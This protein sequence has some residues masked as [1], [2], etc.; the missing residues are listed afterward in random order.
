[1]SF[2]EWIELLAGISF[3][4]LIVIP[5]IWGVFYHDSAEAIPAFFGTLVFLSIAWLT[6]MLGYTGVTLIEKALT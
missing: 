4:S 5:V 1:M 6:M 2:T 3:L